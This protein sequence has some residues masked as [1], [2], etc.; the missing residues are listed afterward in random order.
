MVDETQRRIDANA[1][2]AFEPPFTIAIG[3]KGGV[4]RPERS[5]PLYR[6]RVQEVCA[7]TTTQSLSGL[8]GLL[9]CLA[10]L[11]LAGCGSA[12]QKVVREDS[13]AP[14][15]YVEVDASSAHQFVSVTRAG[16]PMT[17]RLPLMLQPGDIVETREGGAVLRLEKGEAVLA[18]HTRVRLGSLEV[19]F[20]R[21]FANVRGLF[22]AEDDSVAADVEG[23]QFMFES[24]PG[25]AMRLV[26]L[27]GVVRCSDKKGGWPPL[28][29]EAGR[30]MSLNYRQQSNP[31][32]GPASDAELADIR[33]WADTIRRAPKAGYC[34]AGGRVFPTVS[35][36]CPGRFE[37]SE[38]SARYQCTPGW[39]CQYNQVSSSIR[40]DCRGSFHGDRD[41]AVRAC[42]EPVGWCCQQGQLSQQPRSRCAGSYFGEN[43]DAAR[44][45]CAPPTPPT[46]T[47]P[48]G[49]LRG[50]ITPVPVYKILQATQVWCCAGGSVFRTDRAT[51]ENRRGAVYAD[52][53]SARQHCVI[54]PIR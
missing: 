50:T 1:T 24:W 8:R 49:T 31:S 12:L 30:R 6:K 48:T 18:P 15:G 46:P 53:A 54:T 52:E 4:D 51:C 37:S 38:Q 33:H 7:M 5:T 40:A 43:V 35:T 47:A 3:G 10:A 17:V 14:G 2:P 23:T 21:I 44:R 32:L 42:T 13:R 45:A 20:G 16:Q 22:R 11:W 25:R 39:C 9:L 19:L 41:S 28:R 26:V 36:Q 29:V 34:C 27:Q